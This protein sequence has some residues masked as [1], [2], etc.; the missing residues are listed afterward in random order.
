[1]DIE[2]YMPLRSF[3]FW[4][5]EALDRLLDTPDSQSF[6]YTLDGQVFPLLSYLETS[7]HRL[8]EIK[9]AVQA[10]KLSI[11]PFYTQFDEWLPSGE[12]MV[13]NCLYG[14]KTSE[15]FGKP[16]LV[17]YLPD[18]FGHPGQLPQI[19][20]GFGIDSLLFMRGMPYVTEDFPD[21]FTLEGLDGSELLTVHFREGYARLYGKTLEDNLPQFRPPMRIFPYYDGYI[22]Y[23][24]LMDLTVVE[25]P[26]SYAEEI[27]AY[28][29][30]IKPW[31][32]SGEL[33][34]IVGCDHSPPHLGLREALDK[35]NR[36]QDEIFFTADTPDGFIASLQ[37]HRRPHHVQGELL[38]S[39]FQYLLLGALSTRSWLKR[40][41]FASELMLE[42]YAEP[43]DALAFL[44]GGRDN[45]IFL[46]EAWKLMLINQAHDSIHGSSVD[47]V[48][49]EMQA[50]Y[51]SVLQICAG[52]CHRALSHIGEL[53]R[54]TDSADTDSVIFYVPVET[55][56]PQYAELWWPVDRAADTL[57][58]PDGGKPLAA[59]ILRRP[60]VEYNELGLPR[61]EPYPYADSE[62][63]LVEAPGSGFHFAECVAGIAA[64]SVPSL[65]ENTFI[66]GEEFIEN[67]YLW[68]SA[69]YGLINIRDKRNG[70]D[71]FGQNLILEEEETG[72][73]WD[74]SPA[75]FP[76]E[77]VYSNRG[78]YRAEVI[79]WGPVRAV[80][81][82]E[83]TM[84][85]PC[86][87]SGGRRSLERVD[88][89]VSYRAALYRGVP[90]IDITL[91]INNTAKDHRLS[92]LVNPFIRTGEIICRTAF[93]TIRRPLVRTSQPG[94]TLAQPHTRLFP[95]REYAALEDDTKGFAIGVK[96]LYDYT[97]LI[98]EIT[99]DAGL[100][101]TLL[102]AVG[103]MTRINTKM[104][105]GM[106]AMYPET[107]GSQCLGEQ[108][109]EYSMI[110]YLKGEGQAA[111][112]LADAFLCPPVA[113]RMRPG[114]S[115]PKESFL[116]GSGPQ[117]RT[118]PAKKSSGRSETPLPRPWGWDAGNIRFSCFKRSWD[119]EKF[120][121]RF[122]EGEGIATMVN[123]RLPAFSS[124]SRCRMDET[125]VTPLALAG[126]KL[127]LSV[128]PYEIVTLLLEGL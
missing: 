46:D 24:H 63:V 72:D 101:L 36:I 23:D 123:L 16:M 74:T 126:G 70:A 75:W 10:G 45:R 68:V 76:G 61:N 19:L 59:Q 50:R 17:G 100:K 62:R 95:F 55:T 32:P 106:A 44:A 28:A 41:H 2:W 7:P 115:A 20:R 128:N 80:L 110:P 47:E 125:R 42:R 31:F 119:G 120:I 116:S 93:G 85:V 43:L 54:R 48:H 66:C 58:L 18:N 5:Q 86:C 38:G 89:P 4:T 40:L 90:R 88:I 12:G 103:N 6:P 57:F 84:N 121:L 56:F 25:D 109:F 26:V 13:R 94:E 114:A 96:G 91:K 1:M 37:K 34:I 78:Q 35:A 99:G 29:K 82:V 30:K 77:Q 64:S 81:T 21:E 83:T 122:Y 105:K 22:S 9:A 71:Y 39:R 8:E 117:G 14:V 27:I 87:F 65:V 108:V 67:E 113:C 60:D 3:R 111:Q 118:G 73:Y 33:P 79:E 15:Q 69:A 98:D 53:F 112:T 124:V 107:P 102:R 11:G 51:N 52:L 127:C 49:T 97:P 92:L 104:R